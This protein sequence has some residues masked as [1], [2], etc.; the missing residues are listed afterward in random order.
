[1]TYSV[2]YL[3][4]PQYVVGSHN[5]ENNWFMYRQNFTK[6][7]KNTADTHIFQPDAHLK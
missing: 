5:T 2:F 1:M 3:F 7:N 6:K 4:K